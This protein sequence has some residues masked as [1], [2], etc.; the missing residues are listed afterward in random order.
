MH[1]DG[2]QLVR[3]GPCPQKLAIED[4]APHTKVCSGYS[5]HIHEKSIMRLRILS[6][7]ICRGISSKGDK[8][9]RIKKSLAS[10][11]PP[12][13]YAFLVCGLAEGEQTEE[14]PAPCLPCISGDRSLHR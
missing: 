2:P 9:H 5:Q 8:I 10:N 7:A 4:S 13:N 12:Q 11:C 3:P 1:A 6:R 14:P